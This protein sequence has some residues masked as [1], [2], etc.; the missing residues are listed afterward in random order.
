MG[1][2]MDYSTKTRT[3]I[4]IEKCRTSSIAIKRV[5]ALWGMYLESINN[6]Q[7]FDE[8]EDVDA[9]HRKVKTT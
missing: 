7:H 8:V 3:K 1:R 4:R 5:A 9:E 2:E 6:C